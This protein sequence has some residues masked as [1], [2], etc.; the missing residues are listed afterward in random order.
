MEEGE[1]SEVLG[2]KGEREEETDTKLFYDICPPAFL[3]CLSLSHIPSLTIPFLF[4]FVPPADLIFPH[5]V[6]II[7]A[8]PVGSGGVGLNQ[9]RRGVRALEIQII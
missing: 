8:A 6:G 1:E 2:T 5:R 3:A 9:R 7:V 4:F